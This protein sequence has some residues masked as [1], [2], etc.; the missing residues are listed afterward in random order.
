M[1]GTD[2]PNNLVELTVEE[3]AEAHK[4]LYEKYQCWQDYVAWQG[5]SKL[6]ENFDAAKESMRQGG[7]N[8]AKV[9]NNQWKDPIIKEQR[10]A[11]FKKSMEGKWN[12]K[13][14]GRKGAENY[15]AQTYK[16]TLPNGTEEIVKGLKL[17]C[18]KQGLSYNTFYNMCIGRGRKHKGYSAVKIS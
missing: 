14:L 9:S 18:E 8:G 4:L 2:D 16:I 7:K 1:G 17:W 6:T 13:C 5:L 12:S 15:A 11:K 10:V 3:H